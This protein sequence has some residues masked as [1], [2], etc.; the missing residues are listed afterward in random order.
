VSAAAAGRGTVQY[1]LWLT[2]CGHAWQPHCLLLSALLPAWQRF[3]QAILL[4]SMLFCSYTRMGCL[5]DVVT[6]R[7]LYS[8]AIA[9]VHVRTCVHIC[10]P[11][12]ELLLDA[13]CM[14]GSPAP[15]FTRG[16]LC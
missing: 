6:C 1:S 5:V 7:V 10:H 15:R 3:L 9:C 13:L 2:G 16:V 4:P 11:Q 8:L 14:H 12:Q